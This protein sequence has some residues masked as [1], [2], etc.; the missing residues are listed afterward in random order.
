MSRCAPLSGSPFSV[1]V[2]T[3]TPRD[4]TEYPKPWERHALGN[5]LLPSGIPTALLTL[6]RPSEGW[7]VI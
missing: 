7:L 1:H 5:K 4:L 6:A 3:E 2:Y